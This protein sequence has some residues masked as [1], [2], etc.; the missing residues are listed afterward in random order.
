M[1][2][3]WWLGMAGSPRRRGQRVSRDVP[4]AA[5]LKDLDD[6]GSLVGKVRRPGS[7]RPALTSK[8]TTLLEGLR[9]LLEPATM[10]DPDAAVAVGVEEPRKAGA[11]L[12]AMGHQIAK[13][14]I[15]KLLDLLQYHRQV[16]RKT[17]QGSRNPDRDAQFEH[18][19]AA[20][21]AMQAAGKP[22]VSINTTKKSL[23]VTTRMPEVTIGRRAVPI[24]GRC[25][26]SSTRNL[27]KSSL[28]ASTISMPM[29]AASVSALI[30]IRRGSR[31]TQ[32]D[33]GW[34]SWAESGIGRRTL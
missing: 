23:L 13:N 30:S 31:S 7:G 26:I 16:N 27:A 4:S 20:V 5:G 2:S 22:V 3:V 14:S 17:L 24:R 21:V 10:G 28:M 8:D 34:R 12:C 9:Q 32:S 11:A 29:L 6:P 1:V 25:T 18:I 33:A 19:N 15:P